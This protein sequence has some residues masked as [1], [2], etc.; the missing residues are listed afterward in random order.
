MGILIAAKE[1]AMAEIRWNREG[2]RGTRDRLLRM[3]LREPQT[4]ERIAEGLGITRN[5]V[6]SQLALLQREGTVEVRGEVKG[7]RRPAAVYGVRAGADLPSSKA[8][9]AVLTHLVNVLADRDEPREFVAVMRDLGKSVARTA[10]RPE[11]G[12][13]QRIEGAV[14]F[15]RSLGSLAELS[16]ENGTVTISSDGCPLAQVVTS[17]PRT[18]KA[19]ESLISQLTGLPVQERCDHRGHPS[20]R[21]EIRLPEDVAKA[22]A[23]RSSGRG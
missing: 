9:P 23:R 20:C 18:C 13:R 5:A 17:E 3:L 21:F 8:Y 12:P 4:V 6:R 1:E 7:S 14:D 16:E 10:P 2:H 11:G 19:M 15:L 22:R